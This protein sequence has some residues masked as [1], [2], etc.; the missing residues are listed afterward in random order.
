[1]TRPRGARA[2]GHRRARFL[3][4]IVSQ[5]WAGGVLVGVLLTGGVVVSVVGGLHQETTIDALTRVVEPLQVANTELR[6][7]FSQC[8]TWYLGYRLTGRGNYLG[9]YRTCGAD[10]Q[11]TLAATL[12]LARLAEPGLVPLIMSQQRAALAWFRLADRAAVVS[13]RAGGS[14]LST[15]ARQLLGFLLRHQR[16]NAAADRPGQ[17]AGGRGGPWRA[18]Q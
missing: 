17:G 14:M 5:M 9:A 4:S 3:G 12:R 2:G 10:F 18:G 1:M 16:S 13:S 11:L 6:S 8:Q 15:A 7:G